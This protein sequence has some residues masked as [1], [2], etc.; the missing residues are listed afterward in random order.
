MD[1]CLFGPLKR[2]GNE[3]VMRI[4]LR[5]AGHVSS[6][7]LKLRELHLWDAIDEA[8]KT[9]VTVKKVE[10]G[11]EKAVIFPLDLA[12][13]LGPSIRKSCRNSSFM[14]IEGAYRA[15]RALFCELKRNKSM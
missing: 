5:N 8:Y 1:V 14:I 7:L 9:S 3:A 13:P 10:N 2:Y 12:T 6:G 4:S 11:F 15:S